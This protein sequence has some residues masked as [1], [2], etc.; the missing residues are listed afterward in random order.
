MRMINV[1]ILLIIFLVL[2]VISLFIDEPRLRLAYYLV[3]ALGSLCFIN[4]YLTVVYYIRLRNAPG[5]QGEQGDKGPRG[6][7]GDSGKCTYSKSCGIETPRE[8]I[9][10]VV[11]KMYPDISRD[12]LNKPTEKSCKNHTNMQNA[13]P[14]NKQIDLLES[15]AEQTD[16]S[17]EKFLKGIKACIE[18]PD[19]CLV[20]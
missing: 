8:K 20:D 10:N 19:K 13:V 12:C 18:D 7:R 9:L 14:I 4:C 11:E 17:E 2:L 6:A 3:V 16:M 15:I 5:I 1:L